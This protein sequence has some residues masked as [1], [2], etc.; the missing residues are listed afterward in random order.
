MFHIIDCENNFNLFPSWSHWYA[1]FCHFWTVVHCTK[2]ATLQS[3][4][5]E[6]QKVAIKSDTYAQH[7]AIWIS[8]NLWSPSHTSTPKGYFKHCSDNTIG[9]SWPIN[10]TVKTIVTFVLFKTTLRN[11]TSFKRSI[12]TWQNCRG[13]QNGLAKIFDRFLTRSIEDS[14]MRC[15]HKF[16]RH[17]EQCNYFFHENLSVNWKFSSKYKK[18]ST[19]LD[20]KNFERI[21]TIDDSLNF[22]WFWYLW[23]NEAKNKIQNGLIFQL[24]PKISI[25]LS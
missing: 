16:Q 1:Y 6:F 7:V 2:S 15:F 11:G 9:Q 21:K 24:T 20:F 17:S 3:N 22:D 4:V 19:K 14:I 8:F 18:S 13:G 10:W 25:F 5:L 23:K 12:S